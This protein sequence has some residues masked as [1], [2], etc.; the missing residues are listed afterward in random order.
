VAI[1]GPSV[2]GKTTL[3]D[4]VFDLLVQYQSQLVVECDEKRWQLSG[5]AGAC[6]LHWLIAYSPQDPVLFEAN[7]ATTCCLAV[8][9]QKNSSILAATTGVKCVFSPGHSVARSRASC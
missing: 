9:I 6:Q 7:C 3:L 4:R 1:T 8:S 2:S 5:P